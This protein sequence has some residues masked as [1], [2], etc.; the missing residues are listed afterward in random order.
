MSIVNSPPAGPVDTQAKDGV[1]RPPSEGWRSFFVALY[2]V[3]N[4]LT[5]SGPTAERPTVFLWVGRSFWD[6]TLGKPVF[7]KSITPTVWVDAT[8]G[9]V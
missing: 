2:N 9:A 6:T 8:G 5:M 7:L 4:G 3:C 1:L